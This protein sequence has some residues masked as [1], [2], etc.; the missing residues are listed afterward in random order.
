MQ[1]DQLVNLLGALSLAL[2]DAQ[3]QAARE[4]S[5][6]GTSACAALVVLSFYPG[7][8]IAA[9]AP[10]LGLT[11]SVVVRLADTLVGQGLVARTAG[12]VDKRQVR[13]S[14]T[15]AGAVTSRAILEARRQTLD[16]ALAAVPEAIRD[17]AGVAISAMLTGLTRSRAQADH[18][19]RM[20]DEAVCPGADCPVECA[21]VRCAE[22]PPC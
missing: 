15:P 9:L 8:S 6:L 2:T 18:I 22:H 21:A 10:I 20:C 17:A 16:T 11:H 13:L 5:G 7:S 19:C 4:A 12:A 1:Q 3:Q 14:L